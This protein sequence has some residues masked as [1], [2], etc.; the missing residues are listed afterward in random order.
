MSLSDIEHA[1]RLAE[2]VVSRQ[3]TTIVEALLADAV[4]HLAD[5]CAALRTRV[6]EEEGRRIAASEG[7]RYE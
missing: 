1:R 6:D 4:G 2:E 5:E 3:A 7:R